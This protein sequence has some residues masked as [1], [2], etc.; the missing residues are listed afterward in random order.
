[1]IAGKPKTD[2]D[3]Y[4]EQT[5]APIKTLTEGQLKEMKSAKIIMTL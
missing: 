1:M 2:I 3:S 4:F 5:Q